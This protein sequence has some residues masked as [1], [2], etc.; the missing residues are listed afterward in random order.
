MQNL[1]GG[2]KAIGAVWCLGGAVLLGLISG[3]TGNSAPVPPPARPVSENRD[4]SKPRAGTENVEDEAGLGRKPGARTPPV[5]QSIGDFAMVDQAGRPFERSRLQ[6]QVWLASF[7]GIDQTAPGRA[8][9]TRLARLQ[10][11]IQVWPDGERVSLVTF[12]PAKSNG[13]SQQ[14][15]TALS[16]PGVP[17][18]GSWSLLSGSADDRQRIVDG[19]FRVVRPSTPETE[20]TQVALVD[21]QGRVRGFYDGL[22]EDSFRVMLAQMRAVLNEPFGDGPHTVHKSHPDDLFYAPW[23]EDREAAQREA[24]RDLDIRQ[25]FTFEDRLAESGITFVNRAVADSTRDWKLNHY[26]HANGLAVADV[27]GDGRL[28]LYFPRQV[29]GNELWRNLGAGRFENITLKAGVGLTGRVSVSASFADIDNDGDADLFVTTTRHGNALFR[30]DGTGV[31]TDVTREAGLESMTHSSSAEFFDYDRDGRLDL[32]VVNVGQFTGD[33]VGYSG[34]RGEQESPYFIGMKDAFAAHLYPER[35]ERS[36]LYHNEGEGRFR[37]VS[38]ELGLDHRGWSGD[39]TPLDLNQDG[40]IDLYVLCMQGNDEYWINREGKRFES[41]STTLFTVLPWGSMGV[42]AFDWNNDGRIDLSTTNMHAD[43]WEDKPYGVGEKEKASP[44]AMP[45]SYLRSRRPGKNVFGNAFFEGGPD[46]TYREVSETINSEN[47]WPWGLSVGDLNADGWP[48][49]F[50]TSCMNLQWRYHPNSLLLNQ[51]G[52]RFVDSEFVLGVEPRRGRRIAA[53]WYELQCDGPDRNH[54]DCEGESG[55][56]VVWG[57]LGSRGSVMFDLDEDGDLDLV[58]NDFN[59]EPMVLVSNLKQRHPE[60]AS[61]QVQLRGQRSNRDGL[62]ARVEVQAGGQTQVQVLD[63][64]SGYL[65]Q[66]R[67][68][69]YFG[70]DLARQVDRVIVEWPSGVRQEVAGPLEINRTLVVEESGD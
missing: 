35:A 27:D 60:V 7:A 41:Y 29:G 13:D 5:M 3:C 42:K 20:S 2:P 63:G 34:D 37:D 21:P 55:R 58:T 16:Q 24:N 68:P 18:E 46:G 47:Y 9:A 10:R 11:Q 28:D 62:G 30:N 45:E 48:D 32:F 17:S 33:E 14:D 69:L 12:L 56:V 6:G 38:E 70:L 23:M 51:R 40:W 59:S 57:A 65:S 49:A 36:R 67:M 61:L 15:A 8:L 54:P 31:F 50:I 44:K 26:D 1:V 19:E 25:D 53:P 64:Q 4:D 39:A 66:S 52:Q 43:M 22:A